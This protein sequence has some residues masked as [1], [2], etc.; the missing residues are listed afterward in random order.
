LKLDDGSEPI[1]C[2]AGGHHNPIPLRLLRKVAPKKILFPL[3]RS[4][5]VIPLG[6]ENDTQALSSEAAV[7]YVGMTRARDLLY[8]SHSTADQ[9]GKPLLRSSFIDR[10]ARWCDFAEFKR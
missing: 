8:L 1:L 2:A 6:A 9:R 10:I 7:L 4:E 3:N 5:G